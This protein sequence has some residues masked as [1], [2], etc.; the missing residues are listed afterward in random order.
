MKAV[1]ARKPRVT[2]V[3]P[4]LARMISQSVTM[5]HVFDPTIVHSFQPLLEA[6]RVVRDAP[7]CVIT[8]L[9]TNDSVVDVRE[10]LS[11]AGSVPVLFLV[12]RLPVRAAIARLI[13]AAGD[14]TLC[15]ADDPVA[16]E[17]TVIALLAERSAA[18]G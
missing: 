11:A 8:R 2:I 16:I 12:E 17:A 18:R 7:H 1:A 3:T 9:R 4:D 14:A 5:Q 10:L 6:A 13:D 15:E